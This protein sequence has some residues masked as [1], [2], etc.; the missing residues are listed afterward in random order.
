MFE[1]RTGDDVEWLERCLK[2]SSEE[3]PRARKKRERSSAPLVLCGNGTLLHVDAG[4]LLIRNGFTHYPQER[5]EYRYFRGDLDRPARIILLDGSGSISF[6]VLDWLAEQEVPLI[7]ISWTGEVVT[8]IGGNGYSADRDKI[9][10]QRRVRNNPRERLQFSCDLIREK[11][12]NSVITLEDV[13]PRSEFRDETI[14]KLRRE[15]AAVEMRGPPNIDDYG[16]SRAAPEKPISARGMA[17]RCGG[18]KASASQSRWR[19]TRS[20]RGLPPWPKKPQKIGTP[21]TP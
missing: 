2:W 18:Q 4:T 3:R 7:R 15:L 14:S 13:I 19:G 12:R 21:R 16:A 1:P 20:G 8:V 9:D 11:I 17:S 6:D 10:W 5:E